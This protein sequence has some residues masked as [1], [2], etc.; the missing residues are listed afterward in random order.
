MKLPPLSAALLLLAACEREPPVYDDDIGVQAIPAEVGSHAG[1]FALKALNSTL[2]EVP[3]DTQ[4]DRTGGGVNYRLV[5]REWVEEEARY[6]QRS[7]L[8]GGF[9]FEVLGVATSVP[10]P[11][12]RQVPASTEEWVE[13][14]HE[15][16]TYESGGHVQLWAITLDDPHDGPF[17][18]DREA[19]EGAFADRIFDME[20]DGNPGVTLFVSGLVTGEVYAAQRKR[21]GL[22]GV[23]LGP[24]RALGLAQNRFESVTLGNNNS[25]LDASDQGS[26][27]PHPDP[28]ESWFEEARIADGSDCDDVMRAEGEGVISRLRP[29]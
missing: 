6:R 16:G 1:T 17:P 27:A 5:T 2:V 4:E 21:V 25:F 26:A 15:R 18:A 22:E 13:V 29:F 20:P 10:A 3:F 14:D 9:N 28:R 11:T 23:I 7:N 19:A 24:D 12:Y 8:C